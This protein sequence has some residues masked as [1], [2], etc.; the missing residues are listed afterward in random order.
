MDFEVPIQRDTQREIFDYIDLDSME[1]LLSERGFGSGD[2]AL[3][4]EEEVS[5]EDVFLDDEDLD[6]LNDE[7][8]ELD[9]VDEESENLDM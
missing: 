1:K 4:D 2:D 3:L 7:N 9:Q 5:S 6:V 8:Y